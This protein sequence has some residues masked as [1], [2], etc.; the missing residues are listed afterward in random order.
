[1]GSTLSGLFGEHDPFRATVHD[2]EEKIIDGLKR[3]G[4]VSSSEEMIAAAKWQLLR[5]F[6]S[7]VGSNLGISPCI[8]EREI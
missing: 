1:L 8:P 4:R 2:R 6:R 7:D 5:F 3:H